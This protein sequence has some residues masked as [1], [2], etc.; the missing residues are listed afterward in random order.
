MR[1]FDDPSSMTPDERFAELAIILAGGVLRP[2]A[3]SALSGDNP[4]PKKSPNSSQAGLEVSDR[5]SPV[6]PGRR[7]FVDA[8]RAGCESTQP[9]PNQFIIYLPNVVHSVA[10]TRSFPRS[11]TSYRIVFLPAFD[12]LGQFGISTTSTSRRRPSKTIGLMS[13]FIKKTDA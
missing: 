7:R 1:S 5:S 2:H 6:R 13:L 3:R 8:N 10:K 4:A 11:V 12:K 9:A